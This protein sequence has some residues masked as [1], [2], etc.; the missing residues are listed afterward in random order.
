M[1]RQ[2]VFVICQ[3]CKFSLVQRMTDHIHRTKHN[4][5]RDMLIGPVVVEL[6]AAACVCKRA[7]K[8][9]RQRLLHA[10]LASLVFLARFS[11]AL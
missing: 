7:C 8:A 1:Q 6:L 3:E 2:L 5:Y 4:M 11:T 10:A 9:M